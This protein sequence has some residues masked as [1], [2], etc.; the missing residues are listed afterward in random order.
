[1]QY[2]TVAQ[3]CVSELQNQLLNI[4]NLEP[5]TNTKIEIGSSKNKNK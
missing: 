1:M 5:Y 4:A 2:G 3:Y